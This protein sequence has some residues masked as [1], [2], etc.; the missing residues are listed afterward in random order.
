MRLVQRLVVRARDTGRGLELSGS[1][2]DGEKEVKAAAGG[3]GGG[4][5]LEKGGGEEDD[6]VRTRIN[7]FVRWLIGTLLKQ[8]YPGAPFSRELLAL[9]LLH[10]IATEV[11]DNAGWSEAHTKT[12]PKQANASKQDASTNKKKQQQASTSDLGSSPSAVVG[13]WSVAKV[14]QEELWDSSAACR[15]L[16]PLLLS[17]WDRSRSLTKQVTIIVRLPCILCDLKFTITCLF[18][19]LKCRILALSISLVLHLAFFL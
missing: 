4:G 19:K 12:L 2:L 14:L 7:E 15:T 3:G 5:A 13:K 11:L 9:E 8:L 1:S 16:L 17:S 18:L 6:D 10:L